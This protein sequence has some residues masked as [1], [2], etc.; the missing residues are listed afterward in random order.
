[1]L[2]KSTDLVKPHGILAGVEEYHGLAVVECPDA[3]AWEAWLA[4]HHER[5]AGVWLRIAKKG[6][7]VP[8]VTAHEALD[9]VLC[10]GWID[11]LRHAQ[12]QTYFLQRYTHRR[13]RSAWSLVNVAKVEALISSGRMRPSGLAEVEAAK[14]DGRWAAAYR[15]RPPTRT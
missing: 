15:G 6:S 14:A 9:V 11:G 13:P 12:D 10:Y 5:S 2:P 8:S 3:A 4:E 7:G 1:V